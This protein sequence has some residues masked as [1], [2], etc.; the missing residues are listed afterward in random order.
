M[1][2]FVPS[3]TIPRPASSTDFRAAPLLKKKQKRDEELVK[4]RGKYLY[5]LLFSSY[6]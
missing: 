5:N 2:H 3:L 6:I 4:L 1:P